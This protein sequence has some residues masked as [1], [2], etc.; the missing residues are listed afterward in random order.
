MCIEP[1]PGNTAT[2]VPPTHEQLAARDM[3]HGIYAAISPPEARRRALAP[4]RTRRSS[5]GQAFS[6]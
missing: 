3:L 5:P 2:F 6:C 1:V 4:P